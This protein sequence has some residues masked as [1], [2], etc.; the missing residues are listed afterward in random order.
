MKPV[1]KEL[2]VTGQSLQFTNK[3][4]TDAEGQTAVRQFHTQV[5]AGAGPNNQG[6]LGAI[7]GVIEY[8]TPAG[9]MAQA[10]RTACAAC[11]HFDVRAWHK[12]LAL[13]TGPLSKAEDRETITAMKGRIMM[14]GYGVT[15]DAGE[16][17]I[18]AT[19]M[20]HGICRVLSDV[21]EGFVGRD[22]MH[23][24]VVCWREATCPSYV[25]AGSH[26]MDV[27][28]PAQPYGLFKPVDLDAQKIGAQ[29]YDQIL[30]DASG[31]LR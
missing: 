5:G 3:P 31:K 17:D 6:E 20:R 7:P 22:P 12:F 11:R 14:A 24:P 26:R 15:D 29:R 8:S 16:L 4:Q 19:M 25:Q 27:T 9:E 28:T 21:I 30:N 1:K 18:E 13:S 10:A 23:W 2:V